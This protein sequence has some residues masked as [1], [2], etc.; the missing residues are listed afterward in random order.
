MVPVYYALLDNF[1]HNFV[2]STDDLCDF[3]AS[4]KI[5]H[6]LVFLSVIFH[7][8]DIYLPFI[9]LLG[10]CFRPIYRHNIFQKNPPLYCCSLLRRG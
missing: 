9:M 3:S 6:V 10:T 1:C 7:S 4:T 5:L 8:V 2:T